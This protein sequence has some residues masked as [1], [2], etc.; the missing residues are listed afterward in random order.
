ML[1]PNHE[2]PDRH[3][4]QNRCCHHNTKG[5]V[6]KNEIEVKQRFGYVTVDLHLCARNES[7]FHVLNLIILLNFLAY[8][9]ADE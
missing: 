4:N 1:T 3:K 2:I 9:K 8:G 6:T 7:N 5:S